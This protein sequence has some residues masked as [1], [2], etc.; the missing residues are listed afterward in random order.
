MTPREQSGAKRAGE[1]GSPTGS[2]RFHRQDARR[3]RCAV[4]EALG[5]GGD[6]VQS[7]NRQGVP[8]RKRCPPHGHR[9]SPEAMKILAG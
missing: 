9:D 5:I 1:A 4:A 7:D 3:W 6:A 8:R 2:H